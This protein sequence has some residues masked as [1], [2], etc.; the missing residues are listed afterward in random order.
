[1]LPMY[2][3]RP[4]TRLE[5]GLYALIV[6]IAAAMLLDRLLAAMELAERAA[7]EQTVTRV[8][9]AL[10]VR[11]AYLM[12]DGQLVHVQAALKRNPFE[13]VKGAPPNFRGE[14]ETADLARLDGGSWFFDRERAELVYKPRLKRNLAT[15][16]GSEMVRFHLVAAPGTR[17]VLVPAYKYDWD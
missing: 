6:A 1:M 7:M 4:L 14:G 13:L 12:L 15:A 5:I 17:Y 8:N 16:D 3:R 9:A 11:I 10:N 2:L